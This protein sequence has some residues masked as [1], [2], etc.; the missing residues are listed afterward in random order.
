MSSFMFVFKGRGEKVTTIPRVILRRK[1]PEPFFTW[2]KHRY[3]QSLGS[4]KS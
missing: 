3:R 2:I 4:F 1:C